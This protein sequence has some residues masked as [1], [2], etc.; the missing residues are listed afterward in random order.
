M[1]LARMLNQTAA[2]FRTEE[3]DLDVLM[4]DPY[5]DLKFSE[6]GPTC[7]DDGVATCIANRSRCPN[8][9]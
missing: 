6:F 4:F 3:T 5:D 1:K 8:S 9:C 2:Y 7:N